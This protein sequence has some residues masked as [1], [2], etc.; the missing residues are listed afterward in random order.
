[1]AG[2]CRRGGTHG[3]TAADALLTAPRTAAPGT[4][5]AQARAFFADDHVH[6]LLVVDGGRLLAVVERGDLAGAAA[7]DPVRPLGTLTGRTVPPDA[8]LAAVHRQL[9]AEGGRRLAVVD[10]GGALLGLLCLRRSGHGFCADADVH[11]RAQERL[12]LAG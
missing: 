6:A 4:T 2:P 1:M 10:A 9:L 5:V 8:D 11:A 3:A 7:T 12:A